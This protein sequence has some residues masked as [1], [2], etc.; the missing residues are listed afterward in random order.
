[1]K[2]WNFW[3]H[4]FSH[5]LPTCSF[6][7]SVNAL[8]STWASQKYLEVRYIHYSLFLHIQ[9]PTHQV[10][11]VLP[12]KHPE[13]VSFHLFRAI[14]LIQGTF[15]YC[16]DY[17]KKQTPTGFLCQLIS[18]LLAGFLHQLTSALCKL[19][20]QLPFPR[21][22]LQLHNLL[23][24]HL[25]CHLSHHCLFCLLCPSHSSLNV[26]CALCIYYHLYQKQ[27]SPGVLQSWLILNL[28]FN[29]QSPLLR[30]SLATLC[31][32][33]LSYCS[34]YFLLSTIH[35]LNLSC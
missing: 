29:P 7:S 8:A 26:P 23:S 2:Q 25:V 1:M 13:S 14:T 16:W 4:N 12:L 10:F 21:L 6:S 35:S 18:P 32:A 24:A 11:L 17:C 30:S 22:N 34:A 31:Q 28:G 15:I 3:I 5:L 33:H 19:L 9:P 27:L 20:R